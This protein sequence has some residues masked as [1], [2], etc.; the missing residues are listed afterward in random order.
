MTASPCCIPCGTGSRCNINVNGVCNAWIAKP[1]GEDVPG[2]CLL[3]QLTDEEII[4]VLQKNPYAR[5]D[6][7]KV[8]TDPTLLGYLEAYPLLSNDW[9]AEVEMKRFGVKDA[10][11]A[12]SLFGGRYSDFL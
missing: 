1:E 9:E 5:A 3:D 7:P 11:F 2:I 4:C 8:T 12:Y 10:P 6:L